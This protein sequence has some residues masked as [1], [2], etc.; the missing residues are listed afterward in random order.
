MNRPLSQTELTQT[1][2]ELTDWT[3]VNG[4]LHRELKFKSF[5]QAFGFMASVA[6][7]A[8]SMGHHPEW[9][10]VYN[11]V[12]IDLVT[13]DVGNKISDLDLELAK[14]IDGLA[15]NFN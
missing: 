14:K 12:V 6:L 2:A 3:L 5:V 1:L 11:R 9:F 10:N 13:H 8:E 15:Q 4:K 7:V